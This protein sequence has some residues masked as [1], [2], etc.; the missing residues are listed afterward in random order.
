MTLP[1]GNSVR[2][3][4]L[5]SE[6]FDLCGRLE[7]LKLTKEQGFTSVPPDPEYSFEDNKPLLVR[8]DGC[9][10][11]HTPLSTFVDISNVIVYLRVLI[12]IIND[13]IY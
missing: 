13:K 6:Y 8:I 2:N 10:M 7:N 3:L 5:L 4:V 9:T 1:S 11:S 12:L